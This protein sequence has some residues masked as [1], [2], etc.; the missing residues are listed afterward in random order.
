MEEGLMSVASTSEIMSEAILKDAS[1]KRNHFL[2]I[3]N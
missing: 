2:P 1:S 3:K